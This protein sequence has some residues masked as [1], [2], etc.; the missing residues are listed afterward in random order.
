MSGALP[1]PVLF[2]AAIAACCTA[3]IA[4]APEPKPV[5]PPA[6][7][8]PQVLLL[9]SHH[10][11]NNNRDLINLPIEDVMTPRRQSEI[12]LMVS[13]LARWKPTRIAVEWDRSDQA[14]LDKRYAAYLAGEHELTAQEYDQIAFRLAKALGHDR[15]YAADWNES[16]PGEWAQ[17]DFIAWAKNNGQAERFDAFIKDGQA[18]ADRKAAAMQNQSISEWYAAINTRE[19]LTEAHLPYFEIATY[20]SNANNPGAAWVGSWYARNL[21]IFNNLR[22]IAQPGE[23]VF[24]LY[25]SGHIYLLDRFFKESGG[26]ELNDPSLYLMGH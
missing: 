16:A 1:K 12:E 2:L 18:A 24:V 5:E 8:A 10:L 23:R 7:A 4:R 19:A 13:N 20:G 25:G 14:G 26:A 21:R 15:I 22:E 9:G 6:D 11:A 3:A 17:Y